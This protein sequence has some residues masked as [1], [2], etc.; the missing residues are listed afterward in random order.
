M[1]TV[2]VGTNRPNSL[3]R[4]FAEYYV[5]LL[6][7]AQVA[8]QLLDLSQLPE[9]FIFS[10]LYQNSGKNPAFQPFQEMIDQSERLVFVIPEYNGSFP[11]V[12]KAFVD[13]LR[14]PDTLQ[15]KKVALVGL[16]SGI[17]G[18]SLALS[19][20]GDILSYLEANVLGFRVK[21]PQVHTVLKDRKLNSPF[22]QEL[23]QKQVQLFLNF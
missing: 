10:A 20:W 13:G 23:L 11:G 5:D 12:L 4:S 16:G 19:H 9:D 21:I 3:S 6:E 7:A 15:G 18:A 17:Q 1:T 14:Y 22:H 2:I 8:V